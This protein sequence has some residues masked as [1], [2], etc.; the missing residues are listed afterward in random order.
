MEPYVSK[1][2]RGGAAAIAAVTGSLAVYRSWRGG[3][4]L[5]GQSLFD[6]AQTPK[7]TS[8][9]LDV[10]SNLSENINCLKT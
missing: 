1:N 6:R 10:Q 8:T 3:I 7:S 5:Q 9:N 4:W 2:P